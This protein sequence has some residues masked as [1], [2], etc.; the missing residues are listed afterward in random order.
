MTRHRAQ[1]EPARGRPGAGVGLPTCPAVALRWPLRAA[2]T[3]AG[4]ARLHAR[5]WPVHAIRAH[6]QQRAAGRACKRQGLTSLGPFGFARRFD[7][8]SHLGPRISVMTVSLR[9]QLSCTGSRLHRAPHVRLRVRPDRGRPHGRTLVSH[10]RQE[11]HNL[12]G[13][14]ARP[15]GHFDT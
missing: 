13:H 2:G 1:G 3:A 8:S 12:A 7:H 10:T 9:V 14:S 4:G 15:R 6:V 5:R 11:Q